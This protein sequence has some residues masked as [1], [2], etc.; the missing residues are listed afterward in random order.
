MAQSYQSRQPRKKVGWWHFELSV[1]KDWDIVAQGQS[2]DVE[3]F[4]LADSSSVRLEVTLEKTPF[5]KAKSFDELLEAYRKNWEKRLGELKKKEGIEAELKHAFKEDIEVYGHKGALWGFRVGGAPMMAAV[6]YCEKSERSISLTF[7]PRSPDEKD[8][9]LAI[10]KDSKCH[11]STAAERALWSTLLFDIH[12]PQRYRLA[13]AKFTALSSYCVFE[14]PEG[15][16]YLLVGYSG[17]ASVVLDRFKKGIREWFE[18][19]ILKEGMK[20]LHVEIPRLKYEKESV[21]MIAFKGETFSLLKSKK[22]IFVGKIW[23]DK[24][25]DRILTNGAYFPI[26]R[27]EEA[28]KIL[29]D[30]FGQ[31]QNASI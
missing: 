24:K 7:T 11:F 1:P 15:P 20:S 12:L 23:L 4:R 3:I 28:I 21:D 30:L 22:K 25:I 16:E 9:F 10:L 5:E 31:M 8:L 18:K 19:N 2:R 29:E 6:W 13:A 14:D 26:N 27:R 17:L